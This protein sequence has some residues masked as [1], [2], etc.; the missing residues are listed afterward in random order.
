MTIT[1]M[2]VWILGFSMNIA[3]LYLLPVLK[4]HGCLMIF[5]GACF[6]CSLF[7]LVFIPE[8]KG[9]SYEK[10]AQLLER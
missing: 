4:L 8:T 6:A 7:A 3:Y 9:K 1:S 10:I 2:T 5:G